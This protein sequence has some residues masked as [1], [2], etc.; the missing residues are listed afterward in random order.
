M[1]PSEAATWWFRHLR[2]YQTPVM[3]ERSPEMKRVKP[4]KSKPKSRPSK[5]T[6]TDDDDGNVTV[7]ETVGSA[8]LPKPWRYAF[9]KGIELIQRYHLPCDLI[10]CELPESVL[11]QHILRVKNRRCEIALSHRLV[12]GGDETAVHRRL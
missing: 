4:T 6:F 12:M 7:V 2:A 3:Q 9:E 8:E 5:R 11:A 10:I 1:M